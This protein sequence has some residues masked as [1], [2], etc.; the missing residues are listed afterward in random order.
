MYPPLASEQILSFLCSKTSI[1]T[2]FKANIFT[3]TYKALHHLR[4]QDISDLIST[5]LS[6][7]SF[8]TSHTVSLFP[9]THQAHSNLRAFTPAGPCNWNRL[10]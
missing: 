8:H 6:S 5:T 2:K 3:M 10:P 1:I 9:Q 4:P 7:Y